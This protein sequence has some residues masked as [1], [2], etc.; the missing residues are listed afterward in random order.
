MTATGA[1]R[2]GAGLV[3][4]YVTEKLHPL[5]IAAGP[6]PELMVKPLSGYGEVLQE[7][8]D[9]L[10]VGPGLG[11]PK[12]KA[13]RRELFEVLA[14]FPGPVVLDADGLNLVASSGPNKHLRSGMILTPHP[15]EM[16]RLFPE[17]AAMGRAEAARAFVETH[18]VTLLLKGARTVITAPGQPCFF[19]TTGTPGMAGGGQGDVLT[20]LIAALAAGGMDLTE[21]A[22][23][24]A[25]L[26]GRASEI[27]LGRGGE[28]EESLLATDTAGALGAAFAELRGRG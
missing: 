17:S 1:L 6:P 2:G 4:L 23:C 28:S 5:M 20:G 12:S 24:G 3:T 27:A 19:N 7:P 9:V 21:A 10:A 14:D 25:W 15:G 11:R 18:P 26:A 13:G 16:E 8:L 22:C